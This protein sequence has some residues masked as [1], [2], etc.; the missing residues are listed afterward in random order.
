[1]AGTAARLVYEPAD[2]KAADVDIC[3]G[4]WAAR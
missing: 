1:M 2:P 3:V 4:A